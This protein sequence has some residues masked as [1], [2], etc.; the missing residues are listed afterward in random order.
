MEVSLTI[1]RILSYVTPWALPVSLI[2]L[3]GA[4]VIDVIKKKFHWSKFALIFLV[5]TI[6][7]LIVQI[8][9]IYSITGGILNN[10]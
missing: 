6:V 7:L 9:L 1:A 5:F 10:P 4:A 2:L 8:K 3:I